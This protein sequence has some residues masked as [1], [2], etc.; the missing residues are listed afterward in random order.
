MWNVNLIIF[1]ILFIQTEINEQTQQNKTV[2]DIH[3]S[4]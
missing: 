1:Y 3:E 2:V 4:L